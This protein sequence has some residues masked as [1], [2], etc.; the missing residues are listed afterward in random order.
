[1][2]KTLRIEDFR[3]QTKIYEFGEVNNI[4]GK[5]GAGK[6]T[7]KEALCFAFCGT[8]SLGNKSPIHLISGTL[9]SCKVE[10]AT[11]KALV[12]RTLTRRKNS[13]IKLTH[14]GMTLTH[15]QSEF[16]L[17]AWDSDVFLAIF[18]PGY[19]W[20][21]PLAKQQEIISNI[22]PK[23]DKSALIFQLSG[24][25][26]TP[27]EK[28]SFS[29]DK[30]A[31]IIEGRVATQRRSLERIIYQNEGELASLAS[32][33]EIPKAPEI[34]INDL[35]SRVLKIK[36]TLKV[37]HDYET[38]VRQYETHETLFK[39]I[40]THNNKCLE[41][42]AKIDASIKEISTHVR[43]EIIVNYPEQTLNTLSDKL[44]S[45]PQSPRQQA[46]PDFDRCPTCGQVVGSHHKESIIAA[47][48]KSL[49]EW[50]ENM[51]N[52][53]SFNK[54]IKD[55]I[56][57]I[58]GE[59]LAEKSK[60]DDIKKYNQGIQYQIKTLEAEKQKYALKVMSGTA[61]E[62]PS[63]REDLENKE[64]LDGLRAELVDREYK[65]KETS[66]YL[67][68]RKQIEEMHASYKQKSEQVNAI[69]NTLKVSVDR[70]IKIEQALKQLPSAELK[71]QQE[72]LR[73]ENFYL[74]VGDRVDIIRKDG[75][76]RDLLSA[77]WVIKSDI[78]FSVMLNS[79]LAKKINAVF[80][81]DAD[82]LDCPVQT[83]VAKDIQ[84]F[85]TSVVPEQEIKVEVLNA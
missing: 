81:D 57:K 82:L 49:L 72:L 11:D 37:S 24:V 71:A 85:S 4:T 16:A 68:R 83:L 21:L 70:L 40:E 62:K 33:P 12:C 42:L 43:D 77:G 10:V 17:S 47:N 56:E 75:T 41:S 78:E 22:L 15:S 48:D 32:L 14:S 3:G 13:T 28:V 19:F 53:N 20:R 69:T 65:I 54:T 50:K 29:L 25:A 59:Y 6:T 1:M 84:I 31:D 36:D 7:I 66:S 73:M 34:S 58:R 8:D 67:G 61:P 9:D 76:P 52:I 26:L 27:E 45:I 18:N 35:E 74:D 2:L 63:R 80:V 60:A 23:P 51:E 79:H 44:L 46:V 30:R 55:Q 5:N 64:Y 38:L 39:S